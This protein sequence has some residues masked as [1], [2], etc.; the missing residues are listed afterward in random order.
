MTW[1]VVPVAEPLEFGCALGSG[2]AIVA[3]LAACVPGWLVLREALRAR[4]A[5]IPL[6]QAPWVPRMARSARAGNP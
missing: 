2:V 3:L 6:A 4:R 1:F 5:A